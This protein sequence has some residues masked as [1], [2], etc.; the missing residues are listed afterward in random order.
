MEGILTASQQLSHEVPTEFSHF[1]SERD[2]VTAPPLE[3][4]LQE[5]TIV[6]G[7]VPSSVVLRWYNEELFFW[8]LRSAESVQ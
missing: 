6:P 7:D 2:D 5:G 3:V 4:F 1:P 8:S